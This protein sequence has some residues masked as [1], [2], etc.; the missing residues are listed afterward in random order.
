M[1]PQLAQCVQTATIQPCNPCNLMQTD[2]ETLHASHVVY[3]SEETRV[4]PQSINILQR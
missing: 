3:K 1:E 4:S 2:Y